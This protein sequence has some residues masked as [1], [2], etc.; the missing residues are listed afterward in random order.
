MLILIKIKNHKINL[1]PV[2]QILR[3]SQLW[4]EH[5]LWHLLLEVVY[6]SHRQDLSYGYIN[7]AQESAMD[8]GWRVI[9]HCW[10][11]RSLPEHPLIFC[12]SKKRCENNV[13]LFKTEL[14]FPVSCCQPFVLL[15]ILFEYT[16]KTLIV[17]N[18]LL[19]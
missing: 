3:I 6:S 2:K 4:N 19:F 11:M 1:F 10:K 16:C 7:Q 9:Y 8:K 14:I 15:F 13:L 12:E 18:N 5:F 17:L